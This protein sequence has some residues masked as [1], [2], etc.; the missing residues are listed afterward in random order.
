M[1]CIVPNVTG[2]QMDVSFWKWKMST[3]ILLSTS[4]EEEARSL[5]MIIDV[6]SLLNSVLFKVLRAPD[7]P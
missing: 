5:S 6:M 2:M 1:R 7:L 4:P 3:K